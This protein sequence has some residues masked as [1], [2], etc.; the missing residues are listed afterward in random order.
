[1]G[2]ELLRGNL[3]M[4][5]LAILRDQPRYG[6]AIVAELRRRGG[7]QVLD[8]PDGSIYPALHRLERHGFTRS[9]YAQVNGRRRRVYEI[10]PD[11]CEE[12][13]RARQEWRRFA[14]AVEHILGETDD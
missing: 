4:L 8:L 1:M 12:L 5:L 11:G 3:G 7:G 9:T 10:T 13:A 2:T 6:Y 14:A